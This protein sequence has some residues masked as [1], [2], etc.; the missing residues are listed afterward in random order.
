MKLPEVVQELD[1]EAILQ[2][3]IAIV[4]ELLPDYKP[5]ESDD[6]MLVL[7]AFSY[8]ELYL[9]N[10]FNNRAKAFFLATASGSDLDN[11]AQTLYGLYRLQ[12][13]KPYADMEFSLTAT[14]PY[15]MRIPKGFTLTDE[16]GKHF[17]KLLDDVVITAGESK[18]TGTVELQEE[19]A[20]SKVKT[21]IQVSPLPY[22]KVKLSSAFANGSDPED[23][24]AFKERIRISLADKSTAGSRLTY[25]SYALKADERIEEVNVLS[26]SAGV[27]DVIYYSKEADDIMQERI[28]QALNADDVRPLTDKVQVKKANEISFDVTAKIIIK[29]GVDSAA[30]YSTATK[31][32][33]SAR[34][35]IGERVSLAKLIDALMVAGVED[36]ELG[37]PTQSIQTDDYAIAV[38]QNANITYEVA[39]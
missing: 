11:L 22:L 7:R 27:V 32:I 17:A 5:S 21:Q 10:D 12:G 39:Q 19:R 34:F 18:A 6:V 33:Q 28:E 16:T 9:R 24:A 20:A 15:D 30:V 13:A 35:S 29:K 2:Q 26:P 14:L 8:R 31:S 4:K 38:L 36:V 23:D 25:K 1:Y 3:N 37:E